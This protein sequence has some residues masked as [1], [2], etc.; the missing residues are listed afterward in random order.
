MATNMERAGNRHWSRAVWVCGATMLLLALVTKSFVGEA[1][2]VDNFAQIGTL[3]IG[4]G[5]A[6]ELASRKTGQAAFRAACG[7]AIASV[8]LLFWVNGAVGIIGPEKNEINAMYV[9]IIAGGATGTVIARCR[10]KGMARTLFIMAL[11][12]TLVALFALAVSTSS[13]TLE[14]LTING[15]FIALF[16]GSAVLFSKASRDPSTH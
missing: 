15:F 16:V 11:A 2:L 5:I 6:V 7:L 12:Q 8:L 14:I 9:V 1:H 13:G 3:L 10:P 4:L